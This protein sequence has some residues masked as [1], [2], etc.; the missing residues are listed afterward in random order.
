MPT[1]FSGVVAL[2]QQDGHELRPSLEIRAGLTRRFHSTL[3]FDGPSAQSVAEHPSVGLLAEARHRGGLDLCGQD[4]VISGCSV[5][6]VYLAGDGCVL[7]TDNPIGDAGIG[8][9]HLD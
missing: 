8:E 6:R 9:G 4:S 3:E 1:L 5:K 2:A 7:V